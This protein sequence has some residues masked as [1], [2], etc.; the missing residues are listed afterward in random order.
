MPRPVLIVA[1]PG[2][3]L[4]LFAW[5]EKERPLVSILTDGSGSAAASRVGYSAALLTACGAA[6]GPVMGLLADRA[7]YA[8]ILAG[9]AGP[10]MAA[11]DAI[12]AAA[13]RGALVVSDP[14]EGYN[15]MHDLCSAVADRVAA[16]LGG[17]RATFPLMAAS[18]VGEVLSL[19]AATERR[20]RAAVE[21]YL[22]LAEEAA[23]LLRS[24]PR[25]LGHEAIVPAEF[26]WPAALPEP[27]AYERIGAARA[28]AGVYGTTIAYAAHVR[29]L[30]LR[31]R[32]GA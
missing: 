2:H 17:R 32:A 24:H 4:R 21:A 7:W 30:A 28:A 26:D 13:E 11:A 15:P 1:H 5:M 31:L 10:F 12:V 19:D 23:G 20:K 8:A 6:A 3:E 16:G 9:D 18:G 25:A 14:V 22:P 29:P 27:P